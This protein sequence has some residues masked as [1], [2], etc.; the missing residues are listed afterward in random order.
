M[1]ILSGPTCNVCWLR[2][3]AERRSTAHRRARSSRYW[4]GRA[5]KSSAPASNARSRSVCS[6]AELSTIARDTRW[7]RPMLARGLAAAYGFQQVERASR[8]VKLS[9]HHQARRL[10]S[11]QHRSV[12]GGVGERHVVAV[13]EQL[14]AECL[15]KVGVG[16][17][18]EDRP[19]FAGRPLLV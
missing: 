9:Q 1:S 18:D 19:A 17:N 2:V 7:P 14:P 13:G 6:A 5:R 16:P 12:A 15:A 8:R 3:P 10:R 11:S 4:T